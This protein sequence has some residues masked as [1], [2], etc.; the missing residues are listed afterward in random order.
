VNE[1]T[2]VQKFPGWNKTERLAYSG[3]QVRLLQATDWKGNHLALVLS[4]PLRGEM[5][6]FSEAELVR[7]NEGE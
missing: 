6:W 7:T 1:A 5:R 2:I 4:G 3:V